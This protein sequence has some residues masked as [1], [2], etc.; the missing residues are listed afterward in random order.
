MVVRALCAL[1]L[2]AKAYGHGMMLE[3]LSRNAR[4]GI[5]TVGG[6][7]WFSQGCTIGCQSCNVTGVPVPPGFP[8][9]REELLNIGALAKQGLPNIGSY[10]GDLCPNDRSKM[11]FGKRATLNDPKFTTMNAQS[12]PGADVRE[13]LRWYGPGATVENTVCGNWSAYSPWRAPGS[14]P[15]LDPCGVAGGAWTNMSMR[16]GG[17]GPQTGHP[18]GFRGSE[19]APIPKAQRQVW[20]AG[21]L[22]NVS[23][24]SVANHAGGYIWSLCPAD[25]VTEECFEANTLQYDDTDG[26]HSTLRYMYLSGN[27]TFSPNHTEVVIPATRVT[28]GVYPKGST[29]T[30]NPIP[31]GTWGSVAA[32][33]QWPNSGVWQ[34][35]Q[36][37]PQFEPPPGCDE[38]CWG[39][40]PCNVGFTHP[41]FYGW[42]NTKQ[43]PTCASD[44][45]GG[46]PTNGQ[47]C[48]HTTAYLAIIDRVKVP[49][50]PPGEY[51]VRW[52]WDC[53]QS[54]QIWSGC[55]DVT[56]V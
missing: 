15:P 41:S 11:P 24:T 1:A 19:L 31:A 45:K 39:Y 2:V 32:K 55:G 43:L 53:E 33:P 52:R 37:P 50:V 35:N 4:Q 13:C 56:I 6:S 3:P 12:G 17:F 25:K 5:N 8:N 21:G 42:N 29:W 22:A 40:Q 26:A 9:T 23:W 48:C 51:V 10:N 7:M 54:P 47:G 18:Q 14:T 20:K 30:K 34:G 28:E 44:T 27:G 36:Q 16:A 46:V 49:A 38:H